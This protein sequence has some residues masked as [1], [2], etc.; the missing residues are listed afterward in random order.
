MSDI[1]E[2]LR[3]LSTIIEK[4]KSLTDDLKELRERKRTLEQRLLEYLQHTEEV[5]LKYESFIFIPKDRKIR[6]KLKKKER[7]EA[8]VKVLED[9]GVGQP[10]EAYVKLMDSLKGEEEIVQSIKI[11][12]NKDE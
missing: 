9:Y 7:D 12:E 10:K 4:C 5:G 6:K 8:A 3:E 1:R 11:S 2:D